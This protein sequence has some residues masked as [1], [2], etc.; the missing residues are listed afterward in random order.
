[1]GLSRDESIAACAIAGFG[2]TLV[3]WA[4]WREAADRARFA[5]MTHRQPPAETL[6]ALSKHR[7]LALRHRLVKNVVA[8]RTLERSF[9]AIRAAFAPQ[10]VD[11]TNSAYGL[12][13]WALSCFME[14]T[15]GVAANAV[16][17]EVGAPLRGVCEHILRECD[18]AFLT[19]Y[20]ELHPVPRGAR[21]KLHRMQ[22]F[23]TRYRPNPDETHLP[24][25]IDGANVSGS[26]VLGLPT[27]DAFGGGGLTVWDGDRERE[28]FE[29]PVGV[30]EGAMLDSAVWHQSNPITSGERWVIVI[31]YQVADTRDDGSPVGRK[32]AT[33][34]RG[35]GG[36]GGAAE[37]ASAEERASAVRTAATRH[38]IAT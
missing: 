38:A 29:Y 18:A 37:G 24:R 34:K 31:F 33:G 21:R 7:W 17:L 30:G 6:A 26:L 2:A 10:Q 4:R 12:N 32:D 19:W 28:I 15:N 3:A 5:D 36:A 25:H 8:P 11:Y 1:M 9:D 22:S 35:K 16:N 14:Y 23:V 13:H 20:A 27:F